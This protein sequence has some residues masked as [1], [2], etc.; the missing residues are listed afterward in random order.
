[1]NRIVRR[2]L[3]VFA[4]ACAAHSVN[5]QMI[6]ETELRADAADA[7]LQVRFVTPI[8]FLR[9]SGAPRGELAQVFYDVLAARS[10]P[11]LVPSERRIVTSGLP[12]MIV[13]DDGVAAAGQ[14]RKLTIR[15]SQA[16]RFRVRPGKDNRTIE[17]ILEGFGAAVRAAATVPPLPLADATRRYV[18]AIQSSSDPNVRLEAT[19]PASMQDLELFSSRRTV[20]GRT[21][22]DLNL[23]YFGTIPEA[24]RARG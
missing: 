3:A 17:V 21:V 10:L 5:A 6:E 22:F 16:I 1:M 14:A 19:I 18:I 7:L 8:Q 24:E 12:R 9:S 2:C 11:R 20:D 23:G 13:A 4:L 15:F